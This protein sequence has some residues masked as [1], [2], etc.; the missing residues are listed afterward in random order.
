MRISCIPG[1]RYYAAGLIIHS[2]PANHFPSRRAMLTAIAVI[3]FA[4]LADQTVNA[5]ANLADKQEQTIMAFAET[6]FQFAF[7]IPSRYQLCN[8]LITLETF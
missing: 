7:D 1:L 4:D 3:I 6:C 8:G 2:T 5:I